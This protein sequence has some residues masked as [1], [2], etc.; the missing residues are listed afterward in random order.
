MKSPRKRALKLDFW[1][2]EWK[3]GRVKLVFAH[4]GVLGLVSKKVQKEKLP[5]HQEDQEDQ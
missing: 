2:P 3:W 5:T 4:G 1:L